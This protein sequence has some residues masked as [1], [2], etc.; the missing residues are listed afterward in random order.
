MWKFS[1]VLV[2]FRSSF[3]QRGG[4]V[5]EEEDDKLGTRTRGFDELPRELEIIKGFLNERRV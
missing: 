1:R 2:R 5:E 4:S 3:R